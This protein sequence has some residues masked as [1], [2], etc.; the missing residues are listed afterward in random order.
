MLFWLAIYEPKRRV[1]LSSLLALTL[2]LAVAF[3]FGRWKPRGKIEVI[4]ATQVQTK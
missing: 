1:S 3:T 4:R 2:L